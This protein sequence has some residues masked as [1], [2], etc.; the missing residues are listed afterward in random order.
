MPISEKPNHLTYPRKGY[1]EITNNNR[2]VSID[3]NR[4]LPISFGC[5]SRCSS[6]RYVELDDNES[7]PLLNGNAKLPTKLSSSRRGIMLS[8]FVLFYAGFLI[9]G[10]FTFQTFEMKE[11]LKERQLYRD[12]RQGF[13][14][15][16]PSILGRTFVFSFILAFPKKIFQMFTEPFSLFVT[17]DDLEEFIE[18]IVKIN[19]KGVSVL[20]NATGDLN[21]SFGQA[22]IFSATVITTIGK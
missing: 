8:V 18:S 14:T 15:K 19:G 3:T 1:T 4:V 20:R 22:L 5:L 2:Y 7:T 17:D 12:V 16:Y 9:I 10:S 21:W 11:E 13:L 6:K